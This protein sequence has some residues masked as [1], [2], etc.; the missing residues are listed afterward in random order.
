MAKQ[1]VALMNVAALALSVAYTCPGSFAQQSNAEPWNL[2]Q[3]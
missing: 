1:T 3:R 2:A